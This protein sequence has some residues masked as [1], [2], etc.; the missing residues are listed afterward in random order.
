MPRDYTISIES[1]NIAQLNIIHTQEPRIS[2]V[3]DLHM[4][5]YDVGYVDAPIFRL[6]QPFSPDDAWKIDLLPRGRYLEAEKEK[7]C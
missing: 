1:S 6:N 7:R 2:L 4:R 3:H 5:T